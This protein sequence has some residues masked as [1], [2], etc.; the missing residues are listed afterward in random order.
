MDSN[1]RIQACEVLYKHLP[2]A[3]QKRI[4]QAHRNNHATITSVVRD[5]CRR[6]WTSWEKW[7][8]I[9]VTL[10]VLRFGRPACFYQHLCPEKSLRGPA[11]GTASI[12]NE[13]PAHELSRHLL[14]NRFKNLLSVHHHLIHRPRQ[15]LQIRIPLRM[16]RQRHQDI[17]PIRPR[18]HRTIMQPCLP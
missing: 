14:L 2:P 6:D 16:I 9:R 18:D 15:L 13:H 11:C 3:W 5:L 12:H 7:T 4:S 1:H 10:P 17:M 8:G